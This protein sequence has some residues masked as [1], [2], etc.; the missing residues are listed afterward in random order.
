ML[1]RRTTLQALL[2]GGAAMGVPLLGSGSAVAQGYPN[3]SIRL[4]VTFA[5]GGAP[6]V[7]ART[8]GGQVEAQIGQSIV[9][10]NRAGANGIIG[11]Q[12]V[13]NAEPDG[14]TILHASASFVVNPSVHKKLPYDIWKDFAPV[15][16]LGIGVG[17]LLLVN[18]K[19]PATTLAE[20]I[21]YG[22]KNPI[23]YGSPG[24]GNTL[25]LV[26]EL[27]NVKTGLSMQQVP[28]RGTQPGLTALI[29]GDIQAMFIPPAAALTYVEGGQLRAIG[30]TGQTPLKELPT[31]P[32][33]KDAIPDF[34][35]E[36][37][38]M[39]WLA[40]AKTPPEVVARLNR[41]VRAALKNPRVAELTTR[42]GYLPDDKSPEEFAAFLREEHERYALAAKAAKIE[43]Q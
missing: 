34:K 15:A 33:I 16:N 7:M 26:S 20:F 42:A 32:L 31:V 9:V 2:G 23:F 25:H 29:S 1:S 13:A 24:S 11:T 30:F 21:A 6:D 10:D 28:F 22:K 35:V 17:Y 14:Y 3:R 38:W 8:V 40:P 18:P 43:P 12:A 41:E 4:I 5:A 37:A 36:G 19:L 39:G 27:F